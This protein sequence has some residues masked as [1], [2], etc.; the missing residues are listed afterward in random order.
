MGFDVLTINKYR[1]F[2]FVHQITPPFFSFD[3]KLKCVFSFHWRP[4]SIIADFEMTVANS[5][6]S[7]TLKNKTETLVKNM[8]ASFTLE[9][10]GI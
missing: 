9:T 6:N 10:T 1:Y 5:I 8:S 4:G 2:T 3:M 7:S